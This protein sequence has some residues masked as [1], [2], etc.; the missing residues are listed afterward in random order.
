MSVADEIAKLHELLA[1]GAISQ[2]EYERAKARLLD[3]TPGPGAGLAINRLRRRLGDRWIGGVCGGIALL[4][5][6]EAWIW[7]MLFVLGL[8]FGGFTLFAYVVLWIFVPNEDV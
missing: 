8:V 1:R 2:A 7:R 6:V 3:T 4:T 5:G